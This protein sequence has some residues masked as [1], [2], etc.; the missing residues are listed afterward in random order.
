[1]TTDEMNRIL[2]D[3]EVSV[4]VEFGQALAQFALGMDVNPWRTALEQED[5]WVKVGMISGLFV[6]L[7]P[8]ASKRLEI[9]AIAETCAQR[10]EVE[11]A[12]LCATILDQGSKSQREAEGV[13]AN[14]EVQ[15]NLKK[16][17]DLIGLLTDYKEGRLS[18]KSSPRG[19]S[20]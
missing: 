19:D 7:L 1:M 6:I 15:S 16:L 5:R 18:P 4:R 20:G 13:E 8:P 11:D 2:K 17:R 14:Y 12:L 3:G 9:E 10:G